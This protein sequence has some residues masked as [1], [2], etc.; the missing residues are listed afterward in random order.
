MRILAVLLVFNQATLIPISLSSRKL[1]AAVLFGCTAGEYSA[2]G[3]RSRELGKDA[4][5][6]LGKRH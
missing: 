6:E 3:E 1:A 5:P 2:V 4:I